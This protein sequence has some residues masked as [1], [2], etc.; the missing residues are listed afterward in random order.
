VGYQE[1]EWENVREALEE[2]V[3]VAVENHFGIRFP[4]AYRSCLIRFH[5]AYPRQS[6]FRVVTNDGRR[7]GGCVGVLLTADP[8]DPENIISTHEGMGP[9]KDRRVIPITD[10][11]GGDFVCL[12]YREVD[13]SI[14]SIVYFDHELGELYS[15][16]AGFEDFCA[17]LREPAD[18][19]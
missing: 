1:L 3:V 5:G 11:G 6:D 17:M 18:P 9:Y 15:L 8:G 4:E 2:S 12:D 13:R 10:D 16:G 14:P 7:I 19:E